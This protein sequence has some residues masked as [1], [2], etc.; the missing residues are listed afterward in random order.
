VADT[1]PNFDAVAAEIAEAAPEV[2]DGP[3]PVE[4]QD[5]VEDV[6]IVEEVVD[7]VDPI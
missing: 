3:A 6:A 5:I 2:D 1:G 4:G 7:E